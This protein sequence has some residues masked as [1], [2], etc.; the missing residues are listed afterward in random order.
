MG[1]VPL[2]FIFLTMRVTNVEDWSTVGNAMKMARIT[3]EE[4]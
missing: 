3:L 2:E 1:N 4:L